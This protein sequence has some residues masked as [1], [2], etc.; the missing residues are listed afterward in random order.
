MKVIIAGCRDFNDYAHVCQAI[1]ESE[2]DIT[3]LVSGGASG[4]DRLGERYAKEIKIPLKLFP[5]DWTK[6]GKKAGPIRNA[7]MANYSD[8]LIAVWDGCSK[9]TGNMIDQAKQKGLETYIYIPG[10]N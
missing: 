10:I 3:E 9:G 1:K 8:A 5:A 6:H 7:E 4:V 2:F